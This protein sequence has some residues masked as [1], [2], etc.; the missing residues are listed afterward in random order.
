MRPRSS[1]RT[2]DRARS[3][4]GESGDQ[5]GRRKGPAFTPQPR[6][7]AGRLRNAPQ[8]RPH[9]TTPPLRASTTP[10]SGE[11][12][13]PRLH[14]PSHISSFPRDSP[15]PPV[16]VTSGAAQVRPCSFPHAQQDASV[17]GSLG[18]PGR[19]AAVPPSRR[20]PQSQHREGVGASRLGLLPLSRG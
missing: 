18:L 1:R 8:P 4:E 14:A 9:P 16:S 13:A 6:P 15:R 20:P 3:G 10:A 5:A 19:S 12:L 17:R 11:G 7:H 2:S